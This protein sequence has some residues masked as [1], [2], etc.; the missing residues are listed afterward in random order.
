MIMIIIPMKIFK[1]IIRMR[2]TLMIL[3]EVTDYLWSRSTEIEPRADST[4]K[5]RSAERRWTAAE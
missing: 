1:K 5:R 4:M 2:A 3:F